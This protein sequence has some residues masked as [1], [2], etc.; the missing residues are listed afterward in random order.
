MAT[1]STASGFTSPTIT[2]TTPGRA[3]GVDYYL[4]QDTT[5]PYLLNSMVWSAP[6]NLVRARLIYNGTNMIDSAPA[7]IVTTNSS[8][9][10]WAWSPLEMHNYPSGA[11]IQGNTFSLLGDGMNFMS[12][13]VAGDCTLTARLASITPECGRAG[14]RLSRQ[15]LAGGH[16]P[17]RHHQCHHRPAFGRR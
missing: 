7:S 15:Q 14:W 11:S 12:R 6:T 10:A 17:A 3:S 1:R 13:Q 2:P 16:Y 5:S 9:G 8:F 4:G